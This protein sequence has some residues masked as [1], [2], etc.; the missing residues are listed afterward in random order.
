MEEKKIFHYAAYM[1][2]SREDGDGGESNS[3]TN[4]RLIIKDFAGSRGVVIEKEYIDDG[5]TGSNFDRPG[6]KALLEAIKNNRINAIIVKDLSRFGRNATE[7]GRYL[8]NLFPVWGVRLIAINDFYDTELKN[9][10]TDILTVAFKN[11]MNEMYC[12]DISMKIRSIFGMKRRNGE[13]IGAFAPYGYLKDPANKNKL[14]IDEAAANIIRMIFDLKIEGMNQRRI[15]EYLN[16]LGV[17]SPAERLA[18]LGYPCRFVKDDDFHWSLSSVSKI[19]RDE[20]YI[21][22]MVQGKTKKMSFKNKKMT[23][24]NKDDWVRVENAVPAII[25]RRTFEYVQ[26]LNE[27]DTGTAGDNTHVYLFSG[28]AR[29][30]DCGQTMTRH[31]ITQKGNTSVFYFC[32]E[33]TLHK[34][35]SYHRIKENDLIRAV[36]AAIREQIE[37]LLVVGE[38]LKETKDIPTRELALTSVDEKLRE[39][40]D[41]IAF[42]QNGKTQVYEDMTAGVLDKDGFREMMEMFTQRL[43]K[44]ED[45]VERLQREKQKLIDDRYLL[46]PWIE[47]LR[48]YRGFTELT[49]KMLVAMVEDIFVFEGGKVRVTF[50][51]AD[52]I[53]DLIRMSLKEGEEIKVPR[54]MEIF[55]DDEIVTPVMPNPTPPP[56]LP[57]WLPDRIDENGVEFVIAPDRG[58]LVAAR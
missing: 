17:P 53:A 10:A 13:F 33:H 28:F 24:V 52:Q 29:C 50:R 7:T 12:R 44:A 41:E 45:E 49:R 43:R 27:R 57:L 4:Q 1:R 31:K 32:S 48:E 40:L 19:L 30:A 58:S 14:I 16:E 37:Y 26:D 8:E 23:R 34:T 18:A 36:S 47:S 35:C 21:G 2:L 38:K 6:F 54:K 46:I 20:T 3:I 25:S 15:A 42:C 39:V 9:G 51:Y 22:T 55:V 5:Y 11:L 56:V